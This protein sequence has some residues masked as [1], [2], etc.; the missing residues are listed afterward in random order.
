M[1]SAETL[2]HAT[3]AAPAEESTETQPTALAAPAHEQ[4]PFEEHG[5]EQADAQSGPPMNPE[6]V[7]DVEVTIPAEEVSAA[8][9][10]VLKKYTSQARIP[11]FRAGK[12]P[13]SLIRSRF[14][15]QI[16]Q[17]I[18]E[19][20]LPQHFRNALDAQGIQPLSQPQVTELDLADG[21]PLRFKALFEVMPEINLDGYQDVKVQREPADLTEE[22]FEAELE[23]VR[24]SRS[25]METVE[26]DRELADGDYAQISF[27][28]DLT[29]GDPAWRT[30]RRPGRTA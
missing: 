23:R 2:T 25:T 12:V 22:E 13:A 16:R 30:H 8:F 11:G 9:R 21:Q 24:D 15:E 17:D 29:A 14:D 5:H 6:C 7:R 4:M 10:R 27:T 18:V 1:S 3:E 28:G 20:L 19:Q 26:E